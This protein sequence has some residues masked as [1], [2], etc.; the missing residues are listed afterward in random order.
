METPALTCHREDF[1][2]RD[3]VHYLNCAYMSPLPRRVE[4]AGVRGMQAKRNPADVTPDDFFATSDSVRAAFAELIGASHPR[5]VSL[6]PSVSYGTASLARN[7]HTS[8]G[9]EI[10]LLHEQF[11]SHVYTWRR[12]AAERGLVLRTIPP[13]ENA[14]SRGRAWNERI[15]E[16]ISSR[17]VAV[18]VPTVHW[19]DG[20]R[21]DLESIGSRAREVDSALIVDGTQ[22]VGAADLNV[23]RFQP[24]GLVCA[25][26]KWLMGPYSV[27]MTYWSE[28]Y[29][30]G[31]PLEE[32]WISRKGSDNFAGLVD[33]EDEYLPGAVRFDV[34]ERS[35]F[36]LMPMMLEALRYIGELQ[37]VRIASYCRNLMAAFLDSAVEMGFRVEEPDFRS[38]HLIGIRVPPGMQ[39][40]T[41]KTALAERNVSVSVRGT[42][43]RVAPNVYNDH[44]DVDRLHEALAACI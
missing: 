29:D 17:T 14:A 34:G 28:R 40:E 8:P 5:R 22:S 36:I 25:G 30:G 7:L 15:L 3:D 18:C 11:P 32:N 26:Y 13:P 20:T 9:D 2:L 1:F 37:P 35:N 31:V 41:L 24:D 38:D 23:A 19:T 16:G 33:Y 27:A 10:L 12:L 39:L 43:V 21:F 4:A 6:A 44:R 42:A